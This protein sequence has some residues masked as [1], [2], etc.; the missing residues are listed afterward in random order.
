M[1]Q[2][3][4]LTCG[5]VVGMLFGGVVS[6]DSAAKSTSPAVKVIFGP[7]IDLNCRVCKRQGR[8]ATARGSLSGTAAPP[9]VILS[10]GGGH[11]SS[12]FTPRIR[13]IS[14][15]TADSRLEGMG[16]TSP[17]TIWTPSAEIDWTIDTLT[18]KLR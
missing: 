11:F 17:V 6:R 4:S 16:T 18:A 5:S 1:A 10:F 9:S 7:E 14:S 15:R 13:Q 12:A 2:A 8:S 3:G